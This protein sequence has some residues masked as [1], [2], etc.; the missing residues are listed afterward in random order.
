MLDDFLKQI[1]ELDL[2][3][4]KRNQIRQET[5]IDSKRGRVQVTL[6]CPDISFLRLGVHSH[7]YILAQAT[8]NFK[9]AR[10]LGPGVIDSRSGTRNFLK[11]WPHC[12]LFRLGTS[13]SPQVSYSGAW[14]G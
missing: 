6:K 8:P 10:I 2:G 14:G 1:R 9:E 3:E 5:Y 12:V 13:G 7:N 4:V 11:L